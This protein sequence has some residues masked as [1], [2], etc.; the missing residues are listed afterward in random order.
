MANEIQFVRRF[1]ILLFDKKR[2]M[3]EII[4]ST[5]P[6]KARIVEIPSDFVSVQK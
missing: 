3:G 6:P 1:D 2:V 4:I 5:M